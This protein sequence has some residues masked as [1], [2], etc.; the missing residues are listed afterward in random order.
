MEIVH[1]VLAYAAVAVVAVGFV[2]SL[3]LVGSG[4]PAGRV[5]ERYQYLMV[6]L[7]L[8]ASAAGAALLASG[9]RPRDDL[10]LLYAGLAIGVIPLARSFVAGQDSRRPLAIFLAFVV[11]GGV[12]FRLLTTG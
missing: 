4:R 10:H 3:A 11:L 1:R 8:V 7:A 12:L 5:F 9:S 2:W 6:G